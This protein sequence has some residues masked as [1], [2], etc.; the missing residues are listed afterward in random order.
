M[1]AYGTDICEFEFARARERVRNAGV[2]STCMYTPEWNESACECS[3]VC[4]MHMS[5]LFVHCVCTRMCLFRVM[6]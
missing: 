6:I 1:R 3:C 5:A 4:G 2:M